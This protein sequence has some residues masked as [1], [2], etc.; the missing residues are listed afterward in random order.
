MNATHIVMPI[1]GRPESVAAKSAATGSQA[2]SSGEHASQ[3]G[4]RLWRVRP[5]LTAIIAGGLVIFTTVQWALE[6]AARYQ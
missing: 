3:I 1:D 2:T 6:A 4:D 5:L